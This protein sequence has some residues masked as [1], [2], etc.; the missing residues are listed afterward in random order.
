LRDIHFLLLG[1]VAKRHSPI[2]RHCKP[3]PSPTEAQ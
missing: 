3:K 1:G 2:K